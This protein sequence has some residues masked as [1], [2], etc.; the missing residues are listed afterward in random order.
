MWK[1]I[2]QGEDELWRMKGKIRFSLYKEINRYT[3]KIP[4]LNSKVRYVQSIPS[5]AEELPR[6]KLGQMRD[7]FSADALRISSLS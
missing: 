1:R 6:P 3:M 2:F 5:D 7:V 4:E